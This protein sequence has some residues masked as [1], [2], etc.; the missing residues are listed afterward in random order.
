MPTWIKFRL[1][2]RPYYDP[3]TGEI[4]DSIE[5]RR[6]RPGI[7]P[8]SG[9]GKVY[10]EIV[11]QKDKIL[12]W[13]EKDGVLLLKLDILE[14]EAEEIKT[15]DEALKYQASP[16]IERDYNH[17]DFKAERLTDEEAE[18]MKEDIF[19]IKLIEIDSGVTTEP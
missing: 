4:P 1:I 6:N 2:E 8:F 15:R 18:I 5:G 12:E 11:N 7:D 14:L 13:H 10:P 3:R 17:K 9:G 16:K 19:G